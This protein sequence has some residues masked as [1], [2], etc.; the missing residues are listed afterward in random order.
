MLWCCTNVLLFVNNTQCTQKL[1]T[2]ITHGLGTS[3]KAFLR[4]NAASPKRTP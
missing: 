2:T 4:Y 3:V 1:H